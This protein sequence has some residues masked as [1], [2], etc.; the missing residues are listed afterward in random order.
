VR[1]SEERI[2]ILAS[3]IVN[4]LLDEELVDI[5]L[6]ERAFED[7]IETWI[8]HDLEIEDQ[9]NEEAAARVERYKRKI[10]HG[11]SEWEILI[12]KAKDELA[13]ARGYVI[14]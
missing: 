4:R 8:I 3:R 14:R 7:I 11:S 5:T 13:R 2:E 1:L 9:I 12:D 6:T 10:I